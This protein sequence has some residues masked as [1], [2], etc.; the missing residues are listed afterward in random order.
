VSVQAAA[1]AR[2]VTGALLAVSMLAP[3]GGCATNGTQRILR[4]EEQRA[5]ATVVAG[6]SA[7]PVVPLQWN[8]NEEVTMTLPREASDPQFAI[9][10]VHGERQIVQLLKLPTWSQPYGINLT[11]FA[12]GGLSDPALFY[13]KMVFLDAN[14]RTTRQTRQSDFVYRSVGAQGGVSTT[15][16]MNQADRNEAYLAILSETQEGITE[17]DSVMQSSSA[18]PVVV[19][20]GPYIVT[21]MVPTGGAEPPRKL[22]ALA[23][24]PLRLRIAP[25]AKS[26][27]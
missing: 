7:V 13:P 3:L 16:F 21:W 15:V 18:T 27:F 19:P 26:S 12:V 10:G 20:I 14:F 1:S 5:S 25:F 11:S 6:L 17:Q 9:P 23:V 8:A 24:G 22:R 2:A 4:A